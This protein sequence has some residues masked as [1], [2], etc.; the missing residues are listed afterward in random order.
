MRMVKDAPVM[1]FLDI[2]EEY[3][4]DY[5]LVRI[6]EIDH[7]KGVQVGIVLCVSSSDSEL[8]AYSNREGIAEIT[9]VIQG[10]NLL[11]VLGG[12]L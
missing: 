4:D 5:A 9:I 11:P 10:D 6:V 8:Y 3:P 2:G 7:S 1:S 12:L